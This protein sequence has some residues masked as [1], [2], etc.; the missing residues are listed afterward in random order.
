[1]S[2]MKV[3]D[4]SIGVALTGSFCTYSR[5]IKQIQTLV[6]A[7]ANV[8]PIFSFHAQNI[9][10]RFGKAEDF[11]ASIETMTGKPAIR[12][13]EDAEPLGPKNLL[14]LLIIAPCT[15]NTLAKLAH[16]I[17]DTPVLMVAKGHLRNHKPLVISLASNDALGLNFKNVG[18][19]FSQKNIY[20]VP[21]GQDDYHKKPN[22][23]IAD[24]TL[25]LP[26]IESALD[27]IQLQPVLVPPC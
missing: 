15:G 1:M 19:L 23:M 9:D 17:T 21:F 3:A 7:K 26:T 11:I 20:F 6:D 18:M 22:S 13:I 4:L 12:S 14:D 5:V 16:G 2:F 8:T 24:T 27:G 10:T 25:I